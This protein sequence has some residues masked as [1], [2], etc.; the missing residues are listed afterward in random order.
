VSCAL[1]TCRPFTQPYD[2]AELIADAVMHASGLAFAVV[3][4]ILLI[5][6]ADG[7]S[8]FQSAP[9]WIYGIGLVTMFATSAVYNMWPVSSAKLM[10]RR[11]DQSAIFLFIAATYT[12]FIAQ[13]AQSEPSKGLL[14]VLWTMAWIGV[15]LKLGFPGRFERLS[16]VL[17]LALVPTI[18]DE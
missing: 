2:R 11:F 18:A 6:K 13:S 15:I 12:P 7:L 16:I 3:G 9:V 8:G 14:V 17:C 4:M 5:W 10:L 1:P